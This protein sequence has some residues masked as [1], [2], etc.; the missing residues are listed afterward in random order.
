MAQD[1]IKA[2][3]GG[4]GHT[5][6]VR[7]SMW[8]ERYGAP[9]YL[10]GTAPSQFLNDHRDCLV[11][12]AQTL[13]LADGEGRNSVFLAACGLQ[14]TAMDAS[15]VAVEKARALATEQGVSV[16]FHVA[17][18][19][20]WDWIPNVYDL[21]AGI[22][23]QFSPPDD[24][25]AVFEGIKKTLK[26]GGTLLLHGYRPEQIEYG[27]GGPPHAENMYSEDLLRTAFSDMEILTL[28]AYDRVVD[29][30]RGHSGMSALIDLV[31]RK[32][33]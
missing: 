26:P 8:D 10:F 29:E 11:P 15:P 12:G 18:I 9:G 7:P 4:S 21:V 22:F 17:D 19:L 3:T 28:A 20:D 25:K 13:A 1:D 31:A 32:P 23:I 6:P 30:G 14:V 2:D 27:T 16:D 5:Q 33:L 24:R